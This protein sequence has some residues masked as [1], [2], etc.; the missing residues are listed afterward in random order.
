LATHLDD[1]LA[2]GR[3]VDL[4]F[5][6]RIFKPFPDEL[7]QAIL[8]N[9]P[10][11]SF[12][13]DLPHRDANKPDGSSTRKVL[14]LK[15][16]RIAGLMPFSRRKFWGALAGALRSDEVREVFRKHLRIEGD[17]HPG[18]MLHRDLDGYTIKPHP[19]SKMKVCTIQA[20]LP[21]DD[22]RTTLGTTFYRKDG[23]DFKP[24]FDVPF[25]AN[26]AYAFVVTENS[27]HGTR[28]GSFTVPRDTMMMGYFKQPFDMF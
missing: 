27:W 5:R 26:S 11:T 19:D 28:F 15:D 7:Y 23:D 18:P 17:M 2:Q 24:L 13:R 14:A 22:T 1:A 6:L 20:Y 21:A 10:S 9:L 8:L 16:A 12:Y 4:P 25:L 3:N